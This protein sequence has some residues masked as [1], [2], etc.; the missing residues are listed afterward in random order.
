VLLSPP[1]ILLFLLLETGIPLLPHWQAGGHNVE[2]I[3]TLDSLN[4]LIIIGTVTTD[5]ICL[6]IMSMDRAYLG[7]MKINFKKF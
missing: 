7:H 2:G 4:H 5:Y 6:K 1:I 3:F